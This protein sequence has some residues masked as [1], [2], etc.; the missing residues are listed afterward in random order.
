[1][2]SRKRKYRHTSPESLSSSAP[3]LHP[4]IAPHSMLFIQA[5]EADIIRGPN[6][7]IAAKSL[8]VIDNSSIHSTELLVGEGLIRWGGSR[9]TR[10]GGLAAVADSMSFDGQDGDDGWRD[11]DEA[12]WVDRYASSE[13]FN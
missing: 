1:M 8:E 10:P 7:E 9:I 11:E 5:Y 4:D 2:S 6:S 3:Q 12:I 13:K